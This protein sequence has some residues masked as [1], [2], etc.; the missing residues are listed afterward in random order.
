MDAMT[1]T[2]SAA[3]EFVRRGEGPDPVD[4]HVGARVRLARTMRG[5][6]Q[7]KLG[8]ACGIT[9]QQLQKYEKGNNRISASMLHRL[10]NALDMPHSYFFGGL[11]GE[12]ETALFD[13]AKIDMTRR[14]LELMRYVSMM[15]EEQQERLYLLAKSLAGAEEAA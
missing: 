9:F 11:D 14:N 15:G 13:P 10:V 5:L 8:E 2:L 12:G 3:P 1:A 4:V 7:E 6:S